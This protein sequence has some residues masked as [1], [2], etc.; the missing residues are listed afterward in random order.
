MP[1]GVRYAHKGILEAIRPAALAWLDQMQPSMRVR[2][3]H[4]FEMV[5]HVDERGCWIWR[6][7]RSGYPKFQ[8][9]A[10]PDR[11]V[12]RVH[13]IILTALGHDMTGLV[14][15]HECDNVRCANPAHLLPGTTADNVRDAIDRGRNSPP[16][17]GLRGKNVR[18]AA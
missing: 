8:L 5:D 13:R 7:G 10:R 12:E 15:R 18:R 1:K 11:V 9:Q 3:F 16:P 2:L 17:I 4:L 6:G 14:G